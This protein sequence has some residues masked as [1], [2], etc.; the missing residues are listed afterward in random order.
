MSVMRSL[1]TAH[2]VATANKRLSRSSVTAGDGTVSRAGLSRSS[3]NLGFANAS[4]P[5]DDVGVTV[6]FASTSAQAAPRLTPDA[7]SASP[8][9]NGSPR[10]SSWS[11]I[12]GSS[13]G[14]KSASQAPSV[15]DD[16][17]AG[18]ALPWN[19]LC[20]R[21]SSSESLDEESSFDS[22]NPQALRRRTRRRR[23]SSSAS[24]SASSNSESSRRPKSGPRVGSAASAP[25]TSITIDWRA[26][27]HLNA[28]RSCTRL[29]PEL[30]VITDELNAAS[31]WRTTT[32]TGASR[33]RPSPLSSS[34]SIFSVGGRASSA[35]PL[36]KS[37]ARRTSTS[38][39]ATTASASS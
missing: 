16:R 27:A 24:L 38:T 19:R 15:C 39:S 17:A 35:P 10:A 21:G 33:R 8:D 14:L 23:N 1:C 13:P 20:S 5:T 22:D 30:R 26:D 34:P 6:T 32:T 18:R 28:H 29:K 37:R 12:L 31:P 2:H 11:S 25:R 7:S 36:R 3:L 4:A 9:A